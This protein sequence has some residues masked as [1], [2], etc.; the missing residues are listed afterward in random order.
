MGFDVNEGF[1]IGPRRNPLWNDQVPAGL[2]R[3]PRSHRQENGRLMELFPPSRTLFPEVVSS[4]KPTDEVIMTPVGKNGQESQNQIR[5]YRPGVNVLPD[6]KDEFPK[7]LYL[8]QNKWIDLGRA[9]YGHKKG[10]PF[11]NALTAVRKA[12]GAGRIVVPFSGVN[13]LEMDADHDPGRRERL[14]RFMVDLSCNRTILPFMPV[15]TWEIRNALHTFF[16]RPEP[17][18]VRASIVREGLGNA[19]A[20]QPRISGLPP[21]IEAAVFQNSNSAEMSIQHLVASGNDREGTDQFRAE[22]ASILGFQEKVRA[23]AA[24]ITP[25]QR[26]VAEVS[27]H[28]CKGDIG[29]ALMEVLQEIR[30]PLQAFFDRFR[31]A[32]EF[33]QFVISIYTLE[34]RLSLTLARDQDRMRPINQNDTRDLIWLSVAL[35]YSNLVVSEKYWGHMVRS[36]GLDTKYGT[37]IITDLRELPARLS[38]IGCL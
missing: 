38:E 24:E 2:V 1:L 28:L 8:D 27:E 14:A 19:F 10:E 32:A 13:I 31:T 36:H 6:S 37:T 3:P 15:Q 11:R 16:G 9:H 5:P 33:K 22:E 34:V 18:S 17:I 29:T 30:I 4:I 20:I 26:W 23:S 21:E 25:E 7:L 35:P 12:V